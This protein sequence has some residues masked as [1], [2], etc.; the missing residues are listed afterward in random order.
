M[1]KLKGEIDT[2]KDANTPVDGQVDTMK[3]DVDATQKI[4]DEATTKSPADNTAKTDAEK[5]DANPSE[6]N[7]KLEVP[8]EKNN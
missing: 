2:L 8:A 1:D 3:L 7:A 4:A 5:F 6:D